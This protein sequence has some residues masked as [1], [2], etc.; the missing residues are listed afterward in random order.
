MKKCIGLL[1]LFLLISL[2]FLAFAGGGQ[3][4][5]DTD[6]KKFFRDYVDAFN[7][8]DLDTVSAMWAEKAVYVD[9]ESGERTEGREAIRADLTKVFKQAEKTR[10]SGAVD[11]VR[12]VTP[13]VATVEGTTTTTVPDEDPSINRFTAILVKQGDKWLIDSVEETPLEQPA[14]A[15]DALESLAW[16][17][18][19]WVDDSKDSPVVST[20]R[21]SP[22]R[23]FLT[24]SFSSKDGEEISLLGTQIIGWDPRSQQI[25]SWTFNADG[26]FGD[27]VWSKS[28]DDWMIRSTQTQADGG[29]ASG[30]YVIESVKANS[31]RLRLIGQEVDGEPVP[32]SD[33]ITLTRVPDAEKPAKDAPKPNK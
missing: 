9:R 8:Q 11:R 7:K 15:A 2:T 1:G 3:K 31:F 16:L 17:E 10:L 6:F 25:R 14:T 19:T 27:G 5:Q 20:I 18:G 32:N 13:D 29:T 26:S 4:E 24:R 33:P 23:S 22:N 28:G 12:M 30:T 21:W